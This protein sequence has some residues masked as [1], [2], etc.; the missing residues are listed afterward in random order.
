MRIAIVCLF[1][2]VGLLAS[3]ARGIVSKPSSITLESAMESVGRGLVRMK[4]A[5]VEE[6]GG[7]PFSSGLVASE[8]E[9]TFNIAASG[10][11]NGKLYVEMSPIPASTP[12]AG[13]VGGEVGSSYTASRGNQITVKFRTIL[14]GKTT[15]TPEGAVIVEG[16]LDPEFVKRYMQMMSENDSPVI[17]Y[18]PPR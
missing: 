7:K 5:Q 2:M 14:F 15:K 17:M 8:A 3:C 1:G 11:D 18:G 6:N 10:N 13:K 4:H 9:C 12:I 16:P